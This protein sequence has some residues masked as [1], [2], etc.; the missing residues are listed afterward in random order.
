[1]GDAGDAIVMRARRALGARFRPQG[2][3]IESG[4]DC[5]GLAAFALGVPLE[6]VPCDYGL[7]GG[8][9]AATLRARLPELGFADVAGGEARAGDLAA[10]Q[11]GPGQIHLA[12]YTGR[13]L[14][15]AD[16]SLRR[17]VERPLPA[18]W[19]AIGLWRIR[20]DEGSD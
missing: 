5:V 9:G 11:P 19:A 14:I 4:L 1:M 10:F 6:A 2:R 8:G 17:V 13:T 7:R 15:H 18:P 16:A 20:C 12:I 3:T